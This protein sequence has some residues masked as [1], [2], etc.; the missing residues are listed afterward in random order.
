MALPTPPRQLLVALRKSAL[1]LCHAQYIRDRLLAIY[2]DCA[3]TLRGIT[4]QGDRVL[5]QALAAIG[6]KG[7]F[8]QE[9]ETAM[10]EGRADFAV[11]SL[12]DMPMEMAPG[13]TIAAVPVRED[14]RDALV[15][16]AWPS[17]DALPD[18][19]V[20]GT[21]SLRR[22]AQLRD[23]KPTLRVKLLRGNVN[24]RVQKLDEG[25]YD[26]MVLAAAGLNRLEQGH[27]VSA[28][29]DPAE[30]LP[31]VGQG[32]LALECPS[33][34]TDVIEWLQPLVHRPTLLAITAER[35]F[36]RAL[37]GSCHTPIGG[38]AT[39]REDGLWLRGLI[40][41][42]DG[43]DILRGERTARIDPETGETSDAETLGRALADEFLARGASRFI[44]A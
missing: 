12:K 32:A 2:P 33:A 31:A 11:H 3:V 27:R 38:F 44:A 43:T 16:N 37:S 19:A 39:F 22:E 28:L 20:V 24:T 34:R 8:I 41:S 40:A 14:P 7:L 18:G 29:L 5:D 36:S 6:G 4:T 30:F 13:F 10:L 25:Q 9:I 17:I 26:A 23:R 42:R 15:C 1:S 21:S 35:A